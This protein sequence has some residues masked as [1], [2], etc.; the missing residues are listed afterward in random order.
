MQHWSLDL[1]R[2]LTSKTVVTAGYYGS[3]GTNLIGGFELNLLA[4]GEALN[5]LCAVGASTTPTAPCQLPNQAFFSS[6]QEAILDQ[7]RPYRGYRSITMVQPRYNSNYH[8]L[9]VSGQ[10]R[11]SGASQV[12]LAYTWSKNLTDNP[13][14]RSA[15]PQNSYDI[16]LEKSRAALDRRHILT[17]N[18]VYELP[19]YKDQRGFVG[20]VLGG[21]QVSGIATYQTGLGFTPTVSGYDPAGLGLIPPPLTVARPNIVCD[22]NEGAPHTVQQWFNTACFQIT[23]IDNSAPRANVVGNAARGIINGPSTKRVD[24]TL[25]KNLRFSE[26]F[27][28]Q[29]RGEAFNIFNWT[30]PR[31]LSTAVWSQTTQPVAQGGNGSS[32]FGQVLT[33]RDPRVLQFGAKVFF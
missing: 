7:I 4:P 20:K 9:Q 6:A 32:T 30:N 1:Q 12:N 24:F 8:S 28:V 16:S 11:F 22:P 27:R 15:A 21:W 17:V 13:N 29:L 19:F 25:S 26:R 14:D 31:G 33:F 3:K 5:R 23:P 2:Q 18:Y 10:H